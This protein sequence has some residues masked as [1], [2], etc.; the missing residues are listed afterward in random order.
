MNVTMRNSKTVINCLYDHILNEAAEFMHK[1]EKYNERSFTK[2]IDDYLEP[3]PKKKSIQQLYSGYVFTLQNSVMMSNVIK[4]QELDNRFLLNYNCDKIIETYGNS[5]TKFFKAVKKDNSHVK[6][7]GRKLWK[8][9]AFGVL[10]G[11]KFFSQFKSMR[12]FDKFIKPY[13]QLETEGAIILAQSIGSGHLR[14][15]RFA[16]AMDFLKNSGT[17][18][19]P[20]CVKPDSHLLN[21]IPYIGIIKGKHKGFKLELEVVRAVGKL[22]MMSGYSN[23]EIDKLFWLATSVNFYDHSDI[24]RLWPKNK[25]SKIRKNLVNLIKSKTKN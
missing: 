21:T 13:A 4:L 18:I 5:V 8:R 17:S 14:G 24:D 16:L 7:Y 10:D 12:D 22:S 3:E 20:Y 25:I 11:A 6:T 2:I 23:F 15:L 19:S 1:S 9:F